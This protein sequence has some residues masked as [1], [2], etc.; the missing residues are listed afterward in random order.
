MYET[1]KVVLRILYTSNLWILIYSLIG[2]QETSS[3]KLSHL[4]LYFEKNL[5]GICLQRQIRL[6]K[7]GL[8]G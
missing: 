2:I 1:D 4:G 5:F 3:L 7:K 6:I 8:L